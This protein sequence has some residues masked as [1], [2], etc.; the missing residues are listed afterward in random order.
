M[1]PTTAYLLGGLIALICVAIGVYYLI[2]I[3]NG[4]HFLASK[5]DTSDVKHS[6]VFFGV[7]MVAMIGARFVA[8]T[9]TS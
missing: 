2:P 4:T 5:V 1:K 7:A 3:S 6:L 9:K 8:N